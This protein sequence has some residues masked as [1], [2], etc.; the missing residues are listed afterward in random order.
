M[1]GG[2]PPEH[3]DDLDYVSTQRGCR[4]ATPAPT[5]DPWGYYAEHGRP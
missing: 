3:F 1:S 5:G 4:V 2:I